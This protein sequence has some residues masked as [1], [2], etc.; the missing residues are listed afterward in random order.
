MQRNIVI[1]GASRGIGEKISN[2]LSALE[3]YKVINISRTKNKNP[4][5]TSLICDISNHNNV[6]RIFKKIKKIDVLINNAGVT[7]FSKNPIQNFNKIIKT[8]L[9]SFYYCSHEAFSYLKK[10]NNPSIINISSINAYQAFPD[11]PGYVSSKG[12][13]LSLTK[14]LALD[15]GKH[16]IKVNSISLGYINEGMSKM[17]FRDK[18]KEKKDLIE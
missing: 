5:I 18:K 14:A 7:R 13:V 1:T 9:N 16:N 15:Y 17:S 2:Y 10:S 8:N 12:G 11:N 6:K 3:N 4:K